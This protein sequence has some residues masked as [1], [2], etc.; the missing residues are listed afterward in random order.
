MPKISDES[1]D[2]ILTDPPYPREFMHCY[3]YLAE[4]SPRIMK[5]GASLLTLVGHYALED[6]IEKFK[7]KL[8]YRWLFCMNQDKG[9]HARMAMGIDVCW[10]PILWYVKDAYPQGRGFI[11]D[12]VYITGTD[13]QNKKRHKWEQDISWAIFFIQKLT[14]PGDIVLDPFIG[15]GTTAVACI[16]TDRNFIG[17]EKEKEYVDIARN[18]IANR[19]RAFKF[20]FTD[21]KREP[22]DDRFKPLF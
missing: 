2:L 19:E 12:M 10:K 4:F 17:I 16:D 6:V 3:D 7:G 18:R 11:K 21:K 14:E 5:K 13:G 1:I 22:F 8:K 9:K 20:P 15:S